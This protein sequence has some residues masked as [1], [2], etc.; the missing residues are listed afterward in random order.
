[1]R[2]GQ[3]ISIIA[4]LLIIVLAVYFVAGTYARYSTAGSVEASA[5]IAKWAVT[6]KA[7]DEPVTTETKEITFTVD[8][9]ADV[10]NGKIA[11]GVTA[12]ATVELDLTGTEVSVDVLAEVGELQSGVSSDKITLTPTITGMTTTDGTTTISLPNG[13]AFTAENGK[14]TVELK[15]SWENDDTN[16]ASDTAIG[17]AGGTLTVPVSFTVKQ[18]IAN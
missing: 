13:E 10:V 7:N 11:P 4:I 16:N 12:T 1:M 8:K 18:H 5:D 17:T 3:V 14:K 6:I 2:K 9:N 15:L